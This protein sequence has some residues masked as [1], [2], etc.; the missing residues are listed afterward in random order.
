MAHPESKPESG[1]ESDLPRSAST[2]PPL[3]PPGDERS[4][5]RPPAIPTP[6]AG[7]ASDGPTAGLPILVSLI[8]ILT[9][10]VGWV[11]RGNFRHADDAVTRPSR[12]S[13][14]F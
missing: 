1:P 7:P 2:P 4:T 3:P 5:G 14:L 8:L 11:F 13:L 10:A 12:L 9:L 6:T